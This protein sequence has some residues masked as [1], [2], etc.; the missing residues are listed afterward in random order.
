[1]AKKYAAIRTGQL[2]LIL[3]G[4]EVTIDGSGMRA[5]GRVDYSTQ[6]NVRVTAFFHPP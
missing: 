4:S 3:A 5:T 6:S 1:M 2:R